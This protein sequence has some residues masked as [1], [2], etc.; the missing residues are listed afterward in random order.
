[1]IKITSPENCCGCSACM[2]ICPKNAISMQ[3]DALGFL[4]PVV[5]KEKCINCGL[6]EKICAFN[7]NYDVCQNFDEPIAF[8]AKHKDAGQ[9]AKS[10][11]G[12]AFYTISD[13]VLDTGGVVYGAGFTEHFAVAHQRATTKQERDNFRKSKYVQ[14]DLKNTFKEAK[15]DL[16][17]GK[18]VL[19]SGTA[20]QIAGLKSYIGNGSLSDH[21]LTID[22]IC[23]GVPSPYVLRDYIAYQ[24]KRHKG[25]L[26]KEFTF[27][28]KNAHGWRVPKES[29]LWAD[30]SKDIY[31][32]YSD[33]FYQGLMLRKCCGVCPFTNLKRPGDITIADFWGCEKN[34]PD[35][36]K[37]NKGVS[38]ILINTEKGRNIFERVKDKL[39]IVHAEKKDYMQPNLQHPTGLHSDRDEFERDYQKKGFEYVLNKYR[40]KTGFPRF[41]QRC[42]GKYRSLKR[43][44]LG[45][46]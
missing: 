31:Y 27:R 3:P 9:V 26:L 34:N 32:L 24:E 23:H 5:N 16:Q 22:I 37:E 41:I 7:N 25:K 19:F 1:M 40:L 42:F 11:S 35:F 38:L 43:K 30:G 12:G 33:L 29:F 20:C 45:A 18:E 17:E 39:E 2:S 14:S 15:N 13:Y 4:Y 10:Q 8:G 46:K 36:C 28:D 44:Y 6:C 21:L